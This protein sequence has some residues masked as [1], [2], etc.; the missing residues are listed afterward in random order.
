MKFTK[1]LNCIRVSISLWPHLLL[2]QEQ[3]SVSVVTARPSIDL[4]TPN[5]AS[6]LLWCVCVC[7]LAASYNHRS[8][9][10]RSRRTSISWHL[11]L[12][13]HQEWMINTQGSK[14][15]DSP[16]LCVLFHPFSA[17]FAS[18]LASPHSTICCWCFC[19]TLPQAG[20]YAFRSFLLFV[21]IMLSWRP[22]RYLLG[23]AL[24]EFRRDSR[25]ALQSTEHFKF[26]FYS[27]SHLG[28]FRPRESEHSLRCESL[29]I[30]ISH[31][32]VFVVGLYSGLLSGAFT[33]RSPRLAAA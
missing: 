24:I 14:W 3:R 13:A 5:A 25:D 33:L 1:G 2:K 30:S 10:G 31:L 19:F 20:H 29:S 8:L 22:P 16:P 7:V 17:L 6:S 26:K 18:F 9:Q 4:R 11:D 32:F 27:N 23:V 12:T 21:W 15:G 28:C